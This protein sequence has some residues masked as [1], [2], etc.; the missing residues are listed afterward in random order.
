M[1]VLLVYGVAFFLP[2][3]P[4]RTNEEVGGYTAYLDCF[5]FSLGGLRNGPLAAWEPFSDLYVSLRQDADFAFLALPWSANP[6]LWMGIAFLISGRRLASASAAVLAL[7][8][9]FSIKLACLGGKGGGPII[10]ATNSPAYYTWLASMAMLLVVALVGLALSGAE[11]GPL[12]VRPDPPQGGEGQRTREHESVGKN[13]AIGAAALGLLVFIVALALSGVNREREDREAR[14]DQEKK[15]ADKAIKK[16]P[17]PAPLLALDLGGGVKME[18]VL[19]RAG[20][21]MMGSPETEKDRSNDET[22]HEVTISRA[23][24]MGKF[25]VTQEQYEAVTGNNPS[26]FRGAKNPVETVSWEDAQEFCQKLSTKLPLTIPSPGGAEGKWMV[27]L[28]TEAQWEYAC[29]AG[30]S[31]R[32]YSGDADSDLDAVGW[33]YGNSGG[34]TSPVGGK[35]PNAWGLYDMHGN[36]W[37]WCADLYGEYPM[38]S[39]TDPEG[40]AT[41]TQRVL[42]GGSLNVSAMNCRAANRYRY[43]PDRRNIHNGFRVVVVPSSRS[44]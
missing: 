13:L 19:I 35:K 37:Q 7:L 16:V 3:V 20:K 28:P 21:F 41:G 25:V 44:P 31:T 39:A 27:Q 1:A 5:I 42:R 22:Q 8:F 2:L 38:G 32:F 10:E 43:N 18:L 29:R 34:S 40:A 14:V 36:V 26:Q 6:A 17:S 24:Y 15:K 33:Y 9:G 4:G 12:P 11:V 23:F 30:T